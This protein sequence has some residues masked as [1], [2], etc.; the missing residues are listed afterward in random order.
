MNPRL[1]LP[2]SPPPTPPTS[3]SKIFENNGYIT[4]CLFY[5]E[6]LPE[7]YQN[8]PQKEW[9]S[10]AAKFWKSLPNNLKNSFTKFANDERLIRTGKIT[11][12]LSE[13][14]ELIIIFDDRSSLTDP[15]DQIF[16]RYVR[17]N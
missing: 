10:K 16:D 11:Q 3:N 17:Y 2:N 8:L 12:P 15:Y 6:I 7:E 13:G 5:K 4:F 9:I 1:I 14:D